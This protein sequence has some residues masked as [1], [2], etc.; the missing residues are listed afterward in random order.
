MKILNTVFDH[1]LVPL[2]D[3]EPAYLKISG[4]LVNTHFINNKYTLLLG[5]GLNISSDGPTTSLNSWVDILNIERKANGLPELPHIEPEILQAHYMNYLEELL[6]KFVDY[7]G[8]FILP[9]Y[10]K[11]WLHSNQIV[12]LSSYGNI[13]TKICGITEDYGLLIAK[14]LKPNSTTEYTG[15]VFNLQPDGNTFDIFR[16]LI[17]KKVL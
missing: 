8:R 4:L 1:T 17:A 14:E 15:A 7:G 13:R 9:E 2:V 6:S 10:Y 5:C 16:G 11:Y 12:T 3:L